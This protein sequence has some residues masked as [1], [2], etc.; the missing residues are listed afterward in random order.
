MKKL[1]PLLL[2]TIALS[3]CGNNTDLKSEK[4]TVDFAAIIAQN[5]AKEVE[6]QG[7]I[8]GNLSPQEFSAACQKKGGIIEQNGTI[9]LYEIKSSAIA[10]GQAVTSETIA[11]LPIATIADGNAILA[12][13][14]AKDRSVEIVLNGNPI[15]T[16][17]SPSN[18]L[19]TTDGGEL[20]FRLRPGAFSGVKIFVYGCLNQAM[21]ETRCPF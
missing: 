10:N 15:S 9:C 18:R 3:A 6:E 21:L 11:D 14:S 19:I 1:I 2:A 5:T 8:E 17:P 20:A 4:K 12:V 13:G 16:V 7:T